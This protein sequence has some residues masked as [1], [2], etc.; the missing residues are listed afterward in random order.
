MVLCPIVTD[1]W[2]FLMWTSYIPALVMFSFSYNY[3]MS[4]TGTMEMET[5]LSWHNAMMLTF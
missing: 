3:P 2:I 5:Q 1:H 4:T